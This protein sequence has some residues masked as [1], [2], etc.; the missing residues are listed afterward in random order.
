MSLMPLN[1]ASED[2]YRTLIT[3]RSTKTAL[4]QA[5]GPDRKTLTAILAAGLRVPDHGKLAPWRFIVLQ[6]DAQAKLGHL[7]SAA[8]QA[9]GA[10][11]AKTAEK[12][13]GYATQAPVL[14]VAVAAPRPHPVIPKW[15]QHLSAGA[16]CMNILN[17]ATALGVASQWLTGWAAYSPGVAAGLGLAEG[18]QI[19][20]F[21]FLGSAPAAPPEDRPRPDA[22]DKVAWGFPET[23][24]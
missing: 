8:M 7:I 20:G 24:R 14:V 4:M 10:G 1:H 21:L 19:A 22:A 23:S 18:E 11:S 15:E 16:A 12:M 5:P 9:E 6:G 13:Q 3:R 17:A 2:A